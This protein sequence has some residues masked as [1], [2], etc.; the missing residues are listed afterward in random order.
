MYVIIGILLVVG[1]I[2]LALIVTYWKFFLI[3]LGI[4][5]VLGLL[6]YIAARFADFNPIGLVIDSIMAQHDNKYIP[7]QESEKERKE[8]LERLEVY[9]KGAVCIWC[10][11]PKSKN[12]VVCRRCRGA[13]TRF[14][15]LGNYST[16]IGFASGGGGGIRPPTRNELINLIL[17]H[18]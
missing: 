5:A 18:L 4:C 2:L 10:K 11:G 17:P 14:D 7:K 1:L 3:F 15:H 9:L 12:A 6:A 16:P 8:K 13:L